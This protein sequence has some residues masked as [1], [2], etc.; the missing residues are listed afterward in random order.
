MSFVAKLVAIT[1]VVLICH[2]LSCG[3]V[4]ITTVSAAT[5]QSILTGT[6]I[7]TTSFDPSIAP[8]DEFRFNMLLFHFGNWTD[9][10]RYWCFFVSFAPQIT[11]TV[12]T[13]QVKFT[14]YEEYV[15]TNVHIVTTSLDIIN[16]AAIDI[17]GIRTTDISTDEAHPS[18]FT[19]VSRG[20]PKL[21]IHYKLCDYRPLFGKIFRSVLD[22]DIARMMGNKRKAHFTHWGWGD[23][24][25][26]LGNL[27][28]ETFFPEGEENVL[29]GQYDVI[30]TSP[31]VPANG[32][33][34][35]MAYNERTVNLYKYITFAGL[36][37]KHYLHNYAD[38]LYYQ[39]TIAVDENPFALAIY[40]RSKAEELKFYK[41]AHTLECNENEN[42]FWYN[43][44]VFNVYPDN[45][46]QECVYFHFGGGG[47]RGYVRKAFM[48]KL[49]ADFFA[50]NYH[51]RRTN[52]FYFFHK[53]SKELRAE[54]GMGTE[55]F[56][57]VYYFEYLP[58]ERTGRL[59][60]G[61]SAPAV[62]SSVRSSVGSVEIETETE[63][64]LVSLYNK[65]L[66]PFVS[67]LA[68]IGI[69]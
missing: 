13:D 59:L 23:F 51:K 60:P 55:Y 53:A 39:H 66:L 10:F 17:L 35:L 11:Y 6:T 62:G 44:R 65:V 67:K 9:D 50:L 47:Q 19:S 34:A 2:D 36:K 58:A 25:L 31:W 28:N 38:T 43:G 61:G 57:S 46:M 40:N 7:A 48:H 56:R 15:P 54:L 21:T 52:G 41:P 49:L 16:D 33:Y 68:A 14:P 1:L 3:R 63:T 24:D 69:K 32:P 42:F 37:N 18:N 12:L 4:G 29:R 22:S 64:D 20:I 5:S 26:I 30:Q 8:N 45:S 27:M